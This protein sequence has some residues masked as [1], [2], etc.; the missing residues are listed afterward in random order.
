MT[1]KDFEYYICLIGSDE[2]YTIY[3]SDTYKLTEFDILSII[4]M[5]LTERRNRVIGRKLLAMYEDSTQHRIS[6][7]HQRLHTIGVTLNG[8]T[9]TTKGRKAVFNR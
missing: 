9:K 2:K 4:K 3:D 7:S 6:L 5:C 1:E 8:R